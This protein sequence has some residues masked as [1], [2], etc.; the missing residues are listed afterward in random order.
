M[1]FFEIMVKIFF[2]Y[3]KDLDKIEK[4]G[5][6]KDV[7]FA[8]TNTYDVVLDVCP[9]VILN[10]EQI[11]KFR[12]YKKK[13][14][15]QIKKYEKEQKEDSYEAKYRDLRLKYKNPLLDKFFNQNKF[16]LAFDKKLPKGWIKW[17]MLPLLAYKIGRQFLKFGITK[18]IAEKSF[19]L[20]Q[21]YWS[22]L[23]SKNKFGINSWSPDFKIEEHPKIV[24]EVF[25]KYYTSIKR[26]SEY[27][28]GDFEVPEFWIYGKIPFKNCEKSQISE[29]MFDNLLKERERLKKLL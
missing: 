20:E 28:T 11:N 3:S 24:K 26:V 4:S 25:G 5:H 12:E 2:H 27:K 7:S 8:K 19:V 14:K 22:P 13:N 29:E 18:E 10:K 15:K 23:F 1:T 21:K 6:I 16:V 17:G 9:E